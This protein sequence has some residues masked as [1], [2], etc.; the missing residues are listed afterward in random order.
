MKLLI[1]AFFTA[2]IVASFIWYEAKERN[3]TSTQK[4]AFG[5]TALVA[6]ALVLLVGNLVT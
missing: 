6:W 1:L 2:A 4:A 3:L 5:I